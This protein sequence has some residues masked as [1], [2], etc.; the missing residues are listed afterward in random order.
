MRTTV[1][2]PPAVHRR[3]TEL[4]KERRQSLSTVLAELTMRGLASIGEP[5]S[6]RV[7]IATGLP[8]LSIGRPISAAEVSDLVDEE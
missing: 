3:A 8:S 6:V 5:V 2:L 7:D 4:A 1:D